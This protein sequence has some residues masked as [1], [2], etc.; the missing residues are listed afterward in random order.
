MKWGRGPTAP[1]VVREDLTHSGGGRA[2][3]GT[4]GE[5]VPR[6]TKAPGPHKMCPA[7]SR[8]RKGASRAG[9]E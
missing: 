4:C 1:R 5:S 7:S 3:L 9:A 6:G 8:N 2:P